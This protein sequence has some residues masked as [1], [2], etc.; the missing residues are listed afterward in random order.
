MLWVFFGVLLF[1]LC[2]FTIYPFSKS[3]CSNLLFF[4]TPVG[5]RVFALSRLS[6][7]YSGLGFIR[8][9]DSEA[10]ARSFNQKALDGIDKFAGFR[11]SLKRERKRGKIGLH[12]LR[13]DWTL[14]RIEVT[15][16]LERKVSS[17]FRFDGRLYISVSDD[18]HATGWPGLGFPL[19]AYLPASI[20]GIVLSYVQSDVAI[21]HTR[22]AW[23]I[24]QVHSHSNT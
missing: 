10:C 15:P 21:V 6:P 22:R 11:W 24:L 4:C 16:V 23:K 17:F 19:R 5:L 13:L 2:M 12:R 8:G 20:W 7:L 18:G 14:S 1:S 3:F 9:W